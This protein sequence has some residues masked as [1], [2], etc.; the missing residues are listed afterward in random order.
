[1]ISFHELFLHGFPKWARNH[2]YSMKKLFDNFKKYV[3]NRLEK[4]EIT[5]AQN[6][7]A[8]ELFKK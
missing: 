2:K 8:A 3:E 7:M 5:F 1:M 4:I 6:N